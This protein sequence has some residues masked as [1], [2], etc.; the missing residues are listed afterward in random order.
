MLNT[1]IVDDE[2]DAVS[3]ILMLLHDYC[4]E[5]TVTGTAN[6]LLDG[7]RQIKS[8]KPDLVFLDVEMPNGTGFDLVECFEECD[9]KIIFVTAYNSYAIQA[10]KSR[11]FDYLLKPIDIEELQASVSRLSHLQEKEESTVHH[12][13]GGQ[14]KIPIS[15]HDGYYY[16]PPSDIIHLKA[17]GSYT[18]VYSTHDKPILVSKNLKE[19]ESILSEKGFFRIHNSHIINID[20]IRKYSRSDGGCVTLSDNSVI[21]VARNR[22]EQFLRMIGVAGAA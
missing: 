18:I 1:I 15:I 2:P 19:F 17:D 9:F 13:V 10:I 3:S 20:H 22:K 5:V 4:T 12:Q 21:E 8:K 11:A 16:M 14:S 6:S 7:I